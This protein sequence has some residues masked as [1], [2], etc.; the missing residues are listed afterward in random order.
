MNFENVHKN[1]NLK[2]TKGRK[3][4]LEVLAK[5]DKSLGVETIF[6]KCREMGIIIN[7]STVYRSVEMFEEKGII[8]KF[9]GNDGISTYK[10]KGEEHRH[11]L[12]CSIC[13]KKVEVP[14]PMRQVEEMVENETG[15][16]LTE[17]N[18]IM[19]G[20]CEECRHRKKS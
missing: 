12:Q 19:K 2:V 11:M 1:N 4:V 18:L 15:F 7:L 17:H 5:S 13:N 3:A 16:V 9:I 20:V 8:D 6:N 14:C 10:L